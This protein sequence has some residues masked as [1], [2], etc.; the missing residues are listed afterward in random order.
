MKFNQLSPDVYRW[1]FKK[2][3]RIRTLEELHDIWISAKKRSYT[4]NKIF[5]DY[6]VECAKKVQPEES[7]GYKSRIIYF[8]D[9]SGRLCYFNIQS[10]DRHGTETFSF[11]TMIVK[12]ENR[13]EKLNYWLMDE[14]NIKMGNELYRLQRFTRGKFEYVTFSIFFEVLKER[15]RSFVISK[16]DKILV[17]KVGEI[18][19]FIMV[20]L[21]SYSYNYSYNYQ[22]IGEYNEKVISL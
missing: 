11:S 12:F 16:N 4:H 5:W 3:A 14:E 22:F 18:K 15:L 21:D 13:E 9:K 6:L 20:D 17:V 1:K 10:N 2:E 8:Y 19:Y 7:K